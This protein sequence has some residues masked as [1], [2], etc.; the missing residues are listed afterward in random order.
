MIRIMKFGQI[1]DSEI[2]ARDEKATNVAPVVEDIIAN[3]RARGDAALLEYCR[4]FDKAELTSRAVTQEE[5]VEAFASV[6]PKVLEILRKAAVNIR[7][8]HKMQVRQGFQTES[9]DGIITGQ[10]IT[11][12]QKV[13]VYVPGEQMWTGSRGLIRPKPVYTTIDND[14]IDIAVPSGCTALDD[15]V[16]LPGY[17]G[18][19]AIIY[20]ENM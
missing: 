2:F 6:D 11:P 7:A 10:K 17:G 13:G 8:F 19:K 18:Y 15:P 16:Q 12:I 14:A 9:P 1:P 20:V 3:V 5:V 4:K